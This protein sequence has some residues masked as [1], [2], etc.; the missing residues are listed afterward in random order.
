VIREEFHI[1]IL[2]TL[3]SPVQIV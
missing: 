2:I 1:L 3:I